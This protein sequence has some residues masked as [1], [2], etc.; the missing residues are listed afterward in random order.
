VLV[1]IG[2]MR[3]DENECED[4]GEDEGED[5]E[6]GDLGIWIFRDL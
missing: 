3:K 1:V 5:E 2:E 4:E 6:V